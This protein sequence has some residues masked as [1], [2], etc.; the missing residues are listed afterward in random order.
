MKNTPIAGGI[1]LLSKL[2]VDTP[3]REELV[4]VFVDDDDGVHVRRGYAYY[5]LI[6]LFVVGTV[7]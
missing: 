6:I 2:V 5:L 4:A 7:H 1:S 3:F